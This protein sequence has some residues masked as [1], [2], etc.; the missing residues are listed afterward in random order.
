MEEESTSMGPRHVYFEKGLGTHSRSRTATAPD[1][2]P[3]HLGQ[4]ARSMGPGHL[5][6]SSPVLSSSFFNTTLPLRQAEFMRARVCVM[7]PDLSLS[8]PPTR[9][10][11]ILKSGQWETSGMGGPV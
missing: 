2:T 11:T 1:L 6:P 8:H 5:V 7:N 9:E 4:D 3:C 10:T